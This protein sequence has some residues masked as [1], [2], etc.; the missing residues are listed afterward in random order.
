MRKI[1]QFSPIVFLI[2]VL[3][4]LT[5]KTVEFRIVFNENSHTDGT[6]EVIY[7]NIQSSEAELNGQQKDFDELIRHYQG[8]QFLLDQ[9]SEGIYIKNR[10]L[11]E[12][13]GILTG[14]YSG[15]FRN[16]KMDNESLKSNNDEI[17]L[18]INSESNEIIETNGKI[19]KSEKNVF[20]SWP[21]AQKELY[22][23]VKMKGN[24]Q[25]A[26]L[27]QMFQEWKENL[28]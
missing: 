14:K 19:I 3:G 8:D 20:I 18:L 6:I 10:E 11:F 9:M 25:T 17:L 24:Q 22:W 13:N 1:I 4:C 16:I 2:F 23:K 7:N 5:F 15:I 27:V 12:K 21:K 28:K 26:S